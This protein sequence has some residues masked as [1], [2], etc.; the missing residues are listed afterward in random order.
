M[1]RTSRRGG[2]APLLSLSDGV[3]ERALRAAAARA[4]Q[5]EEVDV[6]GVVFHVHAADAAEGQG[7]AQDA[8][9]HGAD[10][11]GANAQEGADNDSIAPTEPQ[12]S[13]PVMNLR[14][15]DGASASH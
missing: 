4:S 10:A 14:G 5:Q 1:P 2:D 7:A 9:E 6:G 13:P 8:A 15:G 12:D 11:H 3:N